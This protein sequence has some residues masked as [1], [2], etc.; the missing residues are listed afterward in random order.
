VSKSIAVAEAPV[1]A[2][3]DTEVM[4]IASG[5]SVPPLMMVTATV[6]AA[7][8]AVR[9]RA[10]IAWSRASMASSPLSVV[11]RMLT[12]LSRVFV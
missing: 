6:P 8:R 1:L 9:A 10:P 4:V 3:P 12:T 11:F 2:T 7:A 5:A